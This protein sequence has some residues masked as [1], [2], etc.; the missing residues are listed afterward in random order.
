[1]HIPVSRSND[2]GSGTGTVWYLRIPSNQDGSDACENASL[3][4]A[5]RVKIDEVEISS[6]LRV[7]YLVRIF[8]NLLVQGMRNKS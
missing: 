4:G 8:D 6:S 7:G 5:K 2:S 3:F 1:M